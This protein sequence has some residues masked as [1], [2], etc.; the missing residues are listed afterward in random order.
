M[1][2]FIEAR[3]DYQKLYYKYRA[4]KLDKAAFQQAVEKLAIQDQFGD[5]WQIGVVSGNWYR[6]DGFQWVEDFPPPPD[7][8]SASSPPNLED[9]TELGIKPVEETSSWYLI[10]ES[11]GSAGQ[12]ILMDQDLVLGRDPNNN[13]PLDDKKAS[14]K[15]AIVRK[16]GQNFILTDQNSTNGTVLNGTMIRKPEQLK[17][18]DRIRIGDTLILVDGSFK[19]DAPATMI[20]D[21]PAV[22]PATPASQSPTPPPPPQYGY[23]PSPTP[24]RPVQTSLRS[25]G[26][27][28]ALSQKPKRRKGYSCWIIG[29]AVLAVFIA[30]LAVLAFGVIMLPEIF[31]T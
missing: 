1:D 5:M 18:G 10:I 27:R 4:G 6:F 22:V 21:K 11:G 2:K 31:G 13:V 19:E 25:S 24:S 23:S 12:R 17:S 28:P 20:A 16:L 15:H 29:F 9:K 3:Q 14:R 30:C 8:G 7:L 26:S